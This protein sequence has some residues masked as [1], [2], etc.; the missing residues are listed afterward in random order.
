MRTATGRRRASSEPKRAVI[1]KSPAT[2]ASGPRPARDPSTASA[3][4]RCGFRIPA[5]PAPRLSIPAIRIHRLQLDAPIGLFNLE[6]ARQHHQNRSDRRRDEDR[7]EARDHRSQD[8]RHDDRADWSLPASHHFCRSLGH[9][10]E[11]RVL[12]QEGKP[13]PVAMKKERVAWEQL[14]L[15]EPAPVDLSIPPYRK[16]GNTVA[17]AKVELLDGPSREGRARRQGRP[18]PARRSRTPA[19]RRSR[20]RLSPTVS[21][22]SASRTLRSSNRP[23]RRR[24]SPPLESRFRIRDEKLLIG[25]Q[26]PHDRQAECIGQPGLREQ[27]A[28]RGAILPRF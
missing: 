2:T 26:D 14:H 19:G 17:F 25:P 11:V 23:R 10:E 28:G 22:W 13:V 6:T 5:S 8:A 16:D 27:L 1:R 9:D 7:Q 21:S 12:R 18:L 4:R 15:P 3:T 20:G 24:T